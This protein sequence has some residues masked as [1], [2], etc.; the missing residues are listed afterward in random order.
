M[1]KYIIRRRYTR[2]EW[3]TVYIESRPYGHIEVI[4]RLWS[5]V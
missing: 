3:D 5:V 4:K 1:H 2:S